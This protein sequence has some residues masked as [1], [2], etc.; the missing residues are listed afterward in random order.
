M[1]AGWKGGVEVTDVDLQDRVNKDDF[2]NWKRLGLSGMNISVAGEK[3]VAG[4]GDIPLDDF[5][6]RILLNAQGRLNVMDLVA[7]PG[8]AGGSITQD[9]QT[10]GPVSYTHLDVYKRQCPGCAR[11]PGIR[12]N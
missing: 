5:Y 8:Q 12:S 7:A 9:T 6:G 3:I 11:P 2:L 4:L 1:K 10:P